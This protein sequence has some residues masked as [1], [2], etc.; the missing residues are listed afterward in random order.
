MQGKFNIIVA[1]DH[2]LYRQAIVSVVKKAGYFD[3]VFEAGNGLECLKRMNTERIDIVLLD[4][5]MPEMNGIDT[6]KMIIR[7]YP[8]TKVIVLTQFDDKR[9]VNTMTRLG[10]SGY[11]L[12]NCTEKELLKS[13]N[14]IILKDDTVLHQRV[15]NKAVSKIIGQRETEVLTLLCQGLSSQEIADKLFLSIHTINNHR[16]AIKQKIKAKSLADMI[17]WAKKKDLI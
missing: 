5:Q 11:L 1:E 15:D 3:K 2:P 6:L 10:V 13:L 16:K 7:E 12:K 17:A 4:I 9:Y 8:E 14:R